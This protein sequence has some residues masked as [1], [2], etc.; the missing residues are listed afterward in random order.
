MASDEA[1]V[2]PALRHAVECCQKDGENFNT[3]CL[4]Q[5]TSPLRTSEDIK[6]SVL[7]LEASD[8]SNIFSVC[9]SASSPYYNLV[10]KDDNGNVA[11][12]KAG[13]Y[14]RRQDVPKTYEL[15]G[16]VYVWKKEAFLAEAKVICKN[17]DIYIMPQERSIDIDTPLDFKIA[18]LVAKEV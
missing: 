11:L 1:S 16:A 13:N 12:S 6:N 4:L 15:N 10:E 9:L 14:V 8:K 18:E 3:I 17:S 2:M 5:T 7:Q